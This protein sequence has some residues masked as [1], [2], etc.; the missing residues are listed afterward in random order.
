ME[1]PTLGVGLL[2][3]PAS[4]GALGARWQRINE[5]SRCY[6]DVLLSMMVSIPVY[7]HDKNIVVKIDHK[8]TQKI[9]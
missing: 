8:I 7:K 6:H 1:Q 2:A 5:K 4:C 3:R 9:D